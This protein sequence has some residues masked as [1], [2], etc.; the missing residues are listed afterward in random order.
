MKPKVFMPRPRQSGI[1]RTDNSKSFAGM[2]LKWFE[3]GLCEVHDNPTPWFWWGGVGDVL[4]YHRPTLETMPV[5]PDYRLGL[6][7]NAS[8]PHNGCKNVPWTFWVSDI[9]NYEKYSNLDSPGFAGRD[10][11]F[12]FCGTYENNSQRGA[13]PI[14]WWRPVLDRVEYDK[15]RKLTT[16]Q[17]LRVLRR[18]RFGLVLPGYGPKCWREIEYLG[19]GVVP[20]FTPGCSLAYHNPPTPGMH[21][22]FAKSPEEASQLIGETTQDRWTEMS[23]AGMAWYDRHCSPMGSF[24]TTMEIIEEN[25]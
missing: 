15:T 25:R 3:L 20:V 17:Y 19:M 11:R 22:H 8:P 10:I 6:F 13:R 2:V 7:A 23:N 24:L 1:H 16:Q 21:Y 5:N 18:A 4:L 9:N 12:V 14:G